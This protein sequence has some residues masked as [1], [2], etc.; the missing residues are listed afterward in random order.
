M[1]GQQQH[2]IVILPDTGRSPVATVPLTPASPFV[3]S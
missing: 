1:L 3:P 2:G